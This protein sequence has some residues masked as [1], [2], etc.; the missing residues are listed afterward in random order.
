[1]DMLT[2]DLLLGAATLSCA[3]VA[4]LLGCFATVVMPGLGRLDDRAF[5]RTF[6]AIDR[7]IQRNHPA[8]VVTW[9]GSVLSLLTVTAVGI[10]TAEGA[11]AR[12]LVAASVLYVGGVQLPTMTVNVPLNNRLQA[13]DLDEAPTSS[14]AALRD[15]FEGR[16]NRW[17]RGRS[18]LALAVVVLLL[19]TRHVA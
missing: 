5:L 1:M 17:N 12:L 19:L 8:F 2:F 16:W 6:A 13:T 14:V 10:A 7:V 18:V 11:V 15:A 3:L 4:G 9:G